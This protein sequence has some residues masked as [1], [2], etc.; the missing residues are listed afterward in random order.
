M[1]NKILEDVRMNARKNVRQNA[2]KKIRQNVRR[3]IKKDVRRYIRKN[4]IVGKK[5]SELIFPIF[6]D[7]MFFVMHCCW[8][9]NVIVA[10]S[11]TLFAW[12]EH[13]KGSLKAL[14]ENPLVLPSIDFLGFLLP[15]LQTGRAK[16]LPVGWFI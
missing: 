3:Y 5:Y 2:R 13:F 9:S 14:R 16:E 8:E 4:I 6:F 11:K 7:H 1:L 15:A 10:Y 12:Q